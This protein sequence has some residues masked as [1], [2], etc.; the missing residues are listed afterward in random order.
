MYEPSILLGSDTKFPGL[1]TESKYLFCDNISSHTL[2]VSFYATYV[3]VLYFLLF[4][5]HMFLRILRRCALF[6][7]LSAS[8]VISLLHV[9]TYL[10]YTYITICIFIYKYLFQDSSWKRII[11]IIFV[12][13]FL[14]RRSPLTLLLGI[15]QF[16]D[17]ENLSRTTVS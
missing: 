13:T 10:F 3:A 15:Q 6:H 1:Y 8:R 2:H 4:W 17:P 14:H 12:L 9:R 5:A 16:S 11:L 7:N